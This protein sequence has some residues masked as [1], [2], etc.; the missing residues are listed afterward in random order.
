MARL[1]R[2]A[3]AGLVHLVTLAGHNHQPVFADDDDR[4]QF[5]LA[6]REAVVPRRVAVL[7]WALALDHVHLLLRPEAAA[8]LASAMQALGRRYVAVFNHRH[9]RSG[10]LWAGRYRAAVLQ[11]GAA[12]LE[13]MLFVDSHALRAGVVAAIEDD[14][15]SSAR[16]HLGLTRDALLT[17]GPDWWALGNTPFERE[18]QW[19]QRLAEGLRL[20]RAAALGAASRGGWA[21]GDA[22]FLAALAADTGRPLQPRKRGRPPRSGTPAASGGG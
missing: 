4:R 15:W 11:P 16:P 8:D 7:G 14:L 19:R 2:L 20:P 21:L 9:A 18:A 12:L 17:E 6:L 10:T 3:V 1:P 13:A 22:A 5:L